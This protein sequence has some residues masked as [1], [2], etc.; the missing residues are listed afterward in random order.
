M[1]AI[2]FITGN[3]AILRKKDIP[4]F[5]ICALFGQIAYY[6]CEYNA[7]TLMP[8]ALIMIVLFFTPS[9]SILIERIQYKRKAN[10]KIFLGILALFIGITLVVGA[11]VTQC[12]IESR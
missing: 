11:E 12:R 9:V 8:V 3:K 1:L 2:K 6:E 10:R 5:I 4:I 7:M